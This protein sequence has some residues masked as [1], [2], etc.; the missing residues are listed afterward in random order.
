MY[1]GATENPYQIEHNELFKAIRS[2][3]PINSGSYMV[4]STMMG[5][6]GQIGSYTGKAVAWDQAMNSDFFYPPKP[7]EV[8]A[9]MTPPVKANADGIYPVF[10]PGVTQFLL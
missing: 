3:Q 10:T 1:A 6:I 2:G 8:R 9:D 5:I 4:G 7:E